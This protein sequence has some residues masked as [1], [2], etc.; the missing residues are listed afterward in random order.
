MTAGPA[1]GVASPS[2]ADDPATPEDLIVSS[3]SPAAERWR[4]VA[5]AEGLTEADLSEAVVGL[6]DRQAAMIQREEDAH[7]ILNEIVLA[8][9]SL[10]ELCADLV[11]VLGDEGRAAAIVTTTDGRILAEGGD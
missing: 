7:R 10:T 9:G 11:S 6:L 2:E 5:R 3:P 8:G 4:A 1:P